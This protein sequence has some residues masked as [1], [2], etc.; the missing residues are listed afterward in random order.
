MNSRAFPSCLLALSISLVCMAPATQ[1][2]SGDEAPPSRLARAMAR[3][4]NSKISERKLNRVSVE[5]VVE[6]DTHPSMNEADVKE[7]LQS[8]LEDV[9]VRHGFIPSPN[10]AGTKVFVRVTD[11]QEG[12][13]LVPAGIVSMVASRNYTSSVK[14]ELAV[15]DVRDPEKMREI[16]TGHLA[17]RGEQ[18]GAVGAKRE[19][20]RNLYKDANLDGIKEIKDALEG[21]DLINELLQAPEYTDFLKA[22]PRGGTPGTYQR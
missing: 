15:V 13:S 5:L 20:L 4:R 3:L 2:D 19:K 18:V 9:F 17:L 1:A 7:G 14:L 6:E 16:V 22:P 8:S 10:S 12:I 11:V 21:S